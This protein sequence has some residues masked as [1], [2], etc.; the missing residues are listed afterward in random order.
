MKPSSPLDLRRFVGQW[1]EHIGNNQ[2]SQLG[3]VDVPGGDRMKLTLTT[4]EGVVIEQWVIEE[5]WG[6]IS[7]PVSSEVMRQDIRDAWQLG[8]RQEEKTK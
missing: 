4:D 2:A 7:K 3:G 1:A 5:E 8:K 6:D